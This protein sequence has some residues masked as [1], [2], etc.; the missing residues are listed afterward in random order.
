MLHPQA[1]RAVEAAAGEP[2]VFDEGFDI[3]ASRRAARAEAA[4]H[5]RVPVAEV[6]DV[7]AGGVPCRLYR[8]DG[9]APGVVVHLHG[10]GFVFHDIDVHDNLARSLAVRSGRA[11]L[12]VDYRRPPEHRFP[13]APDDVDAQTLVADLDMLGGH[14]EDA[15][16]RLVELVRRT[17][18]KERE[19]ARDHLLGLFAAVG[20]D[21][22]RVLN[23]RRALASALF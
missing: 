11:V 22:P 20:N 9:A 15:F 8:P 3:D 2:K 14:V 16:V 7:D 5:P 19:R 1:R 6:R 17:S 10:G 23:G 18:D 12:S 13:A 21:D 4:A